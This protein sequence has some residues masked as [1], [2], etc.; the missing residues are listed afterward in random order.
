MCPPCTPST[1]G[2]FFWTYKYDWES[3]RAKGLEP[4]E[5]GWGAVILVKRAAQIDPFQNLIKAMGHFLP[6][7]IHTP[8]CMVHF[9]QFYTQYQRD[10]DPSNLSTELLGIHRPQ[11]HTKESWPRV[12]GPYYQIDNKVFI[13]KGS[14]L[15]KSLER[16]L[17]QETSKSFT[18]ARHILGSACLSLGLPVAA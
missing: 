14:G 6:K 15:L 10:H 12:N 3:Q 9:Q 16:N 4:L 2:V 7:Q 11:P 13:P 17:Q 8:L 18:I 1:H 5:E